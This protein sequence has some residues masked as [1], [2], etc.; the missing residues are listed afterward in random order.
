[1]DD[2]NTVECQICKKRYKYITISHLA[3]HGI[4]SL[5]EYKEKFP[6]HPTFSK[7]YSEIR[8]NAAREQYK[9]QWTEDYWKMYDRVHS[10]DSIERRRATRRKNKE[11]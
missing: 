10:S 6:G 5:K 8:K 9:R 2:P 4:R 11:S 7:A 3:Q 1:M